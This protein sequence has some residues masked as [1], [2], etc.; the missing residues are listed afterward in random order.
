[1]MTFILADLRRFWSGALAVVVL[2]ALSVALSVTVTLQE[3][4][5][6]L[7]SARA[8]EKFDLL[9][10]AAGSETQLAL[11]A[12]FL[13]PAPLPLME[14]AVFSRLANDPRVELAAPV[15]FGD[16]AYGHPIVGTTTGL[17]SSLSP[18][19]AQGAMFS[20]LGEAVVGSD[21]A[22]SQGAE[23][24]PMHGTAETGGETHTAITYKVTGRMAP[25]GTAWDRA[26]LVPIRAVWQ[27]HGMHGEDGH[28]DHDGDEADAHGA[29]NPGQDHHE[30]HGHEHGHVDADAPIDE[31][32]NAQTPG[33]PAVLVKPKTIADAYRLRQEYRT[34][35]TLGVFPAEVLTRLYA[36][37]GDARSLLLA[38]ALGTQATVI[39]AIVLV[40]IMHV[41][42]RRRQIGA[43]RALGTPVRSIVS[44]VWGEL[45]VLF[46]AGI[47]L[48]IVF[49]YLAALTISARLAAST[50]VRLP[51]GFVFDDL[52]LVG[53]F[54]AVAA[55]I[56]IVPAISALRSSPAT[57]LRA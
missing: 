49:G 18:S 10:G 20:R 57:A 8:A 19:L 48:G 22:L 32:F 29:E 11:S 26:I 45:F 6:R 47:A 39:A 15:G 54:A 21:V 13:Q 35:A 44:L 1:M 53:G 50:A 52:W 51:V 30:D 37:L 41:G 23:I 14:G 56:S 43:L 24:K 40:T 9:V 4:A 5:V 25:T 55:I 16:S 3:R 36:T 33:V 46:A 27:L 12:V 7:G 2:I 28:H 42:A 17:I 38:I 31:H 34:G